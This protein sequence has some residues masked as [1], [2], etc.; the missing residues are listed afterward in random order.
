MWLIALYDPVFE[1]VNEYFF[2]PQWICLSIFFME[3]FTVLVPCWEVLRYQSLHRETLDC[4]A[5]WE[6]KNRERARKEAKSLKSSG[7]STIVDT[8]L[9]GKKSAAAAAAAASASS[10]SILTMGALEYVLERNPMP[11]QQYSALRDFSGENVAFL[12]SVTEWKDSFPSSV[13]RS[14]HADRDDNTRELVRERF[15]GALRI[16]AQ[17]VRARDAE[18]PINISS[19]QQRAL[20]AVFEG[21]TRL[22]YGE[23]RAP[24]SVT[25]FGGG[26]D[27]DKSSSS[28]AAGAESGPE[29]SP[30]GSGIV[31]VGAE[32]RAQ[33]WGEVPD[34]FNETIFDDA[35]KSIKYL[36][37]TNTWPKFVRDWR[38]SNTPDEHVETGNGIRRLVGKL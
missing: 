7:E 27:W 11:L 30:P 23:K 3:I 33:Y 21:P 13:R 25:P 9:T 32:D 20:E 1:G 18:F 34:D 31:V 15:N 29:G 12:T 17:F 35:H 36:V 6:S 8:V 24:D 37:L 38:A 2:P 16:Y 10:E 22:L 4:L 26:V 5:R 28:V 14:G 19:A